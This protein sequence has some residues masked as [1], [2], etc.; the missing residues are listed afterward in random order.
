MPLWL[1][2][3]LLFL[4]V[5]PAAALA[6][7]TERHCSNTRSAMGRCEPDG[8]A[9]AIEKICQARP[10]SPNDTEET[11]RES[12]KACAS[13]LVTTTTQTCRDCDRLFPASNT[14]PP[15]PPPETKPNTTTQRENPSQKPLHPEDCRN[16]ESCLQSAAE[17]QRLAAEEARRRR[18][19]KLQAERE[20][21]E[22]RQSTISSVNKLLDNW[23]R[24]LQ[25]Q[26]PDAQAQARYQDDRRLYQRAVSEP[27]FSQR[28]AA[29]AYDP[30]VREDL[31][32]IVDA[33]DAERGF[34]QES[35]E[36]AQAEQAF[37]QV[38]RQAD[39]RARGLGPAA[40]RNPANSAAYEVPAGAS[41]PV[42]GRST[43]G[44]TIA[45]TGSGPTGPEGEGGRLAGKRAG[46]GD[47]PGLEKAGSAAS[48]RSRSAGGNSPSLRELLRRRLAA[49]DAKGRDGI[50][51]G[52]NGA[53]A[54]LTRGDS[55][56]PD[57]GNG[58]SSASLAAELV[59]ARQAEFAIGAEET[60]RQRQ[61]MMREAGIDPSLEATG[62]LGVETA[63]LFERVRQAHR[64]CQARDCVA[65]TP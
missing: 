37:L 22:T 41:P 11:R 34:R 35:V 8:M 10:A 1:H 25:G 13:F 56:A 64:S 60:A 6:A 15:A 47:G 45:V 50:A 43:G 20:T 18:L 21:K 14:T 31:S 12:V 40:A 19:E 7:P 63:S 23:Q 54:G 65:P 61:A 62:L 39:A 58:S 29:S 17:Q 52:G 2:P 51:S 30:A 5:L 44:S 24:N 33:R 38:A 4:L 57:S 53:S 42:K 3:S 36:A 49:G 28:D 46:A 16:S 48:L 9:A 59:A 32:L 55:L 26:P 27:E